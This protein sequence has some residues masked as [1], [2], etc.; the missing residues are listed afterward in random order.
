MLTNPWGNLLESVL[1]IITYGRERNE[2]ELG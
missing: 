2:A 1:R